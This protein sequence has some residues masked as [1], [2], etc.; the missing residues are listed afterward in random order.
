[1]LL[2]SAAAVVDEVGMAHAAGLLSEIAD[3]LKSK[4]GIVLLRSK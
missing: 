1:V 3:E 4:H 2:A